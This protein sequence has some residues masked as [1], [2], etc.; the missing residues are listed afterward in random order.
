[1]KKSSKAVSRILQGA[2]EA[3][4]F[5]RGEADMKKYRVHVPAEVNVRTI[6]RRLRLTQ[7]EFSRRFGIPQGTLRDWEQGR[8][9]PEG[10]WR[11]SSAHF[12]RPWRAT[13]R[14]GMLERPPRT[15]SCA[16]L[17]RRQRNGAAI[18]DPTQPRPSV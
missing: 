2:K 5:A 3:L 8:R 17:P 4:A 16:D 14:Q 12:H 11:T 7:H 10:R 13:V 9:R 1:M 6:R 15:D 18:F